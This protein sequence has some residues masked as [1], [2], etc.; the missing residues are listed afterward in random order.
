MGRTYLYYSLLIFSVLS[1]ACTSQQAVQYSQVSGV[2]SYQS[3]LREYTR[4]AVAY[5]SVESRFFVNATWWSP[6]FLRAARLESQRIS[7]SESPIFALDS[8][9]T[10]GAQESTRFFVALS[11]QNPYWNNLDSTEPS[12]RVTLEAGDAPPQQPTHVRKLSESE[13]SNYRLMFPF[14]DSLYSA[15]VISF[16]TKTGQKKIALNIAG[17]PGAVRLSWEEPR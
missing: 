9:R 4:T 7:G 12:L 15:Y 17:F 8:R 2:S 3:T 13:L 16:P 5:H 6:V 14:A 11:T 10:Q 1:M